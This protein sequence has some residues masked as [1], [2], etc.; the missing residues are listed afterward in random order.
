MRMRKKPN[1]VP[2]MQRCAEL[3]V[4][5]PQE[6]CGKWLSDFPGFSKLHLELGCGKG[7]FT[8]GTAQN[9]PDTLIVA[10]ERVEDAMVIAMERTKAMELNNVRFISGD[11][12]DLLKYFAP[13]ETD[14]IYLNFSDP[15]P[16]RRH[17]DR[18]LTAPGFLAL[19]KS[20]LPVGGEI[21][22]KTDNSGLFEFSLK[23]FERNGFSLS[24]VKRDLHENGPC[25]I[26]TDYEEKFYTQGLKINRCVAAKT[27]EEK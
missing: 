20:V 15:W 21:H 11:V 27:E 10:V 16:S 7:K 14:R 9:N 6:H 12:R 2:R 1:L 3:L 26:M 24:E 18:R 19:Y 22:F 23:S 5:D 13:N 17:E 8:V 25:G 4:T